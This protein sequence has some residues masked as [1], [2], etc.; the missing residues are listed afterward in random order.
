MMSDKRAVKVGDMVNSWNLGLPEYDGC[1]FKAFAGTSK[2]Q[3]TKIPDPKPEVPDEPMTRGSVVTI[4]GHDECVAVRFTDADDLPYPFVAAISC[5]G[6]VDV[7]CWDEI[8]THAA[9]RKIIVQNEGNNLDYREG[10]MTDYTD[11]YDRLVDTTVKALYPWL[12]VVYSDPEKTSRKVAEDIVD[13]VL[14]EL[15]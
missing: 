5:T 6:T 13:Q 9:G 15:T 8:V 4:E 14:A 3:I 2:V 1:E 12:K 10:D 7:F 11:S